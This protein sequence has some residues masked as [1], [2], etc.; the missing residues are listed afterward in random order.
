MDEEIFNPRRM[1]RLFRPRQSVRGRATTTVPTNLATVGLFNNNR[2][3][4]VI[5]VRDISISGTAGDTIGTSFQPGQVG[6]TAGQQA[7]LVCNEATE[8]GLMNFIDTATVY[9]GDYAFGLNAQGVFWWQHDFPYAVIIPNYTLV[10]QDGTA[11]HAMTIS[12]IWEVIEIDQLDYF[13]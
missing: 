7:P 8:P 1:Y 5:V 10:F 6:A 11:A 9:S 3:R 12:I 2:G 4:S 13:Y